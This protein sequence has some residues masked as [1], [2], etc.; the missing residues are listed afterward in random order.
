[1][2]VLENNAVRTGVGP[3]QRHSRDNHFGVN[4]AHLLVANCSQRQFETPRDGLFRS[5]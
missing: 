1:V 2:H 5:P 3:D 4:Q